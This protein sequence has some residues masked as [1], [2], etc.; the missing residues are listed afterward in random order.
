[1]KVRPS[2][3]L[4]PAVREAAKSVLDRAARRILAERLA[5]DAPRKKHVEAQR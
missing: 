5:A 4:D 1:M 2:S 3:A